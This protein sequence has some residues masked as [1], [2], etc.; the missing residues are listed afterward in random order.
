MVS[1]MF[2]EFG[3]SGRLLRNHALGSFFAP[4]YGRAPAR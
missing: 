2:F 4:V 3:F 1:I